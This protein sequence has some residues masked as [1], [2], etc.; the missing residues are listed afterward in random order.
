MSEPIDKHGP[1]FVRVVSS[2][3]ANT[4]TVFENVFINPSQSS[5]VNLYVASKVAD[6]PAAPTTPPTT[7]VQLTPFYK[8]LTAGIFLVAFVCL[9]LEFATGFAWPEPTASQANIISAADFGWKT[10]FG[11]VVGLLTGKSAL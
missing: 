1:H 4:F 2:V 3:A 10:G 7:P 8:G 5:T 9:L 11:V 6:T